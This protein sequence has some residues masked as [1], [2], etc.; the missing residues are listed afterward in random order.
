MLTDKID[1][2]VDGG[3]V[4]VEEDTEVVIDK[5]GMINLKKSDDK[6]SKHKTSTERS[7]D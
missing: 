7:N 1:M 6:N 2:I 4:L 5:H 3:V